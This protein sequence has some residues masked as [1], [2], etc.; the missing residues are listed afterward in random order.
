[1]L[2]GRA[3]ESEWNKY[4]ARASQQTQ[5]NA[6][7]QTRIQST[8]TQTN[9]TQHNTQTQHTQAQTNQRNKRRTMATK[10]Q[11]NKQTNKQTSNKQARL[12]RQHARSPLAC[13][14][15]RYCCI[16]AFSRPRFWL[17]CSFSSQQKKLAHR[18]QYRTYA[19]TVH[20]S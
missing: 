13:C 15:P 1:M 16:C 11:T 9:K 4:T 10:Q 18:K 6:Q 20:A 19:R 8:H 3:R 12:N 14:E 17:F 2:S 7:M 5:R